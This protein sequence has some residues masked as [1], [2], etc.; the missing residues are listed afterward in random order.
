MARTKTKSL[1]LQ[2]FPAEY[3]K[4]HGNGTKAAIAA[5]YSERSAHELGHRALKNVDVQRE[6]NRLT[7]KHEI[8]MDRVLTRLDNLSTK[9]ESDGQY[10]A[11]IKAEEL[12]GKGIGGFVERSLNVSLD[13][14]Q[15]HLEALQQLSRSRSKETD[16]TRITD[17][18][19]NGEE[20]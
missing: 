4:A 11:A 6:I 16:E 13:L 2:R 5:G 12:I 1:K 9:A 3:V 17:I 10:S 7:L 8:S 20:D 15:A 19:E 14:T 18:M